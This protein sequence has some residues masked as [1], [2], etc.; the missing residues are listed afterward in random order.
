MDKIFLMEK[1]RL[2]FI[3][4]SHYLMKYETHTVYKILF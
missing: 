1:N 4:P 3:L 2:E